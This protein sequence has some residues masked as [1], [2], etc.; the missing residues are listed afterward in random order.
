V[1]KERNQASRGARSALA[2]CRVPGTGRAWS[3]RGEGQE[4]ARNLQ[5]VV[6]RFSLH[7]ADPCTCECPS[8][9]HS[10]TSGYLSM[11]LLLLLLQQSSG[12]Q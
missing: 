2:V 10:R 12:K 1:L 9:P 8:Q 7:R 6:P 5:G 11:L 4:V 3:S